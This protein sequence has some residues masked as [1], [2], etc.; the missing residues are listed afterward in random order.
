MFDLRQALRNLDIEVKP[1]GYLGNLPS[2]LDIDNPDCR[3]YSHDRWLA[4]NPNERWPEF[5]TFHEATHILNGDTILY[6]KFGIEPSKIEGK[7]SREMR[8]NLYRFH[9]DKELHYDM[10]EAVCHTTAIMT[11]SLT[12]APFDL[13]A[14]TEFLVKC[15][16]GGRKIPDEVMQHCHETAE[17]IAAAGQVQSRWKKF[18]SAS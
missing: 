8:H 12:H 9:Q 6:R 13:K 18:L 3:G 15:Y 14:E 2:K 1:F 16:T 4:I 10:R 11:A 5:V 17:K 7:P